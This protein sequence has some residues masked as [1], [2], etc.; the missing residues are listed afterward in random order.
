DRIWYPSCRR[1]TQLLS[2]MSEPKEL[3]PVDE[4]QIIAERR[5]KLAALR[6]T[7]PAFPNDF[8]RTHLA[9][10]L[11]VKYGARERDTLAQE[12]IEVSVAGR[13]MLRRLMGKSSFAT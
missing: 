10:E 6:A 12:N 4:N 5:A 9:D 1:R 3:L 11:H 8:Q 7:G 13:M 2:R